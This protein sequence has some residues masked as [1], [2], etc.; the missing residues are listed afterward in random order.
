M[1]RIICFISSLV[2]CA[3]LLCSAVSAS[4]NYDGGNAVYTIAYNRALGSE[5]FGS[6]DITVN[7]YVTD[8]PI[9]IIGTE[10][11]LNSYFAT[12]PNTGFYNVSLFNGTKFSFLFSETSYS[13]FYSYEGY[14]DTVNISI[15]SNMSKSNDFF[16]YVDRNGNFEICVYETQTNYIVSSN[17]NF[18]P[19]LSGVIFPYNQ[20]PGANGIDSSYEQGYNKGYDD[21]VNATYSDAYNLGFQRGQNT[22]SIVGYAIGGFF[23]GMQ[24][25]FG[26]F[27]SI[28]VGSFTLANLLGI[29]VIA[30]IV[31]IIVKVV[32]G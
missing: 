15:V 7:Q 29:L 19:N 2:L 22:D 27:L 30:F 28:G 11:W 9:S 14:D 1:K 13:C 25:F 10:G 21:G 16:L 32:R 6:T 20:V 17:S 26:P 31:I 3:V 8:Y 24:G 18:L 12:L 4:N 5:E 23:E